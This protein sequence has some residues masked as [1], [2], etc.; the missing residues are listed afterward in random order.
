MRVSVLCACVSVLRACVCVCVYW[1][2]GAPSIFAYVSTIW[3]VPAEYVRR[4]RLS[5]NV[6]PNSAPAQGVVTGF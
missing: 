2:E 3:V 5:V 1:G 4:T 6:R